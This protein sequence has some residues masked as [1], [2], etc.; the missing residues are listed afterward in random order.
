MLDVV[1]VL[2]QNLIK[3]SVWRERLRDSS[4]DDSKH[5]RKRL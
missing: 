4:M 1:Y 5:V 3:K 2:Q